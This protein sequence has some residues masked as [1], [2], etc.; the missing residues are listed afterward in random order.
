VK[1]KTGE[2][3]KTRSKVKLLDENKRTVEPGTRKV[4]YAKRL[5]EIGDGIAKGGEG[6]KNSRQLIFVDNAHSHSKETQMAPV[7]PITEQEQISDTGEK[8][9]SSDLIDTGC[10]SIEKRDNKRVR[11]KSKTSKTRYNNDRHSRRSKHG[12]KPKYVIA[13]NNEGGQRTNGAIIKRSRTR[14]PFPYSLL[15]ILFSFPNVPLHPNFPIK[16]RARQKYE[17]RK[18]YEDKKRQAYV[19][20]EL[21]IEREL[22]REWFERERERQYKKTLRRKNRRERRRRSRSPS[23]ER[24]RAR[25]LSRHRG[26]KSYDYNDKKLHRIGHNEESSHASI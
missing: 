7:A 8:N 6:R 14:S 25:S 21:E 5:P 24:R 9:A 10:T 11:S 17:A 16:S 26:E 20:M 19:E 4:K 15:D 18:Q 12:R 1:V 2:L 13:V 22:E 23:R 3:K